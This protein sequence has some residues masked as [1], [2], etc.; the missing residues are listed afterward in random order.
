M[1]TYDQS[2]SKVLDHHTLKNELHD[3]DDNEYMQ[4]LVYSDI[5]GGSN[6]LLDFFI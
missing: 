4:M 5:A 3:V 1:Q 6:K 2:V